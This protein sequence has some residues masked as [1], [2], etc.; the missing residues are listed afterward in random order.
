MEEYLESLELRLTVERLNRAN[1]SRAAQLLNKTNQMN[2]TTRRMTETQLEVHNSGDR[3][4]FVF[5]V[6]DRFGEYGVTGLAGLE[7]NGDCAIVAD[8]VVSCRVMGR[9]VENAM[10]HVL[11]EYACRRGA[12][13]IEATFLP[14]DRNMPLKAFFDRTFAKSAAQFDDR[15]RYTWNTVGLNLIPPHIRL[16]RG[17]VK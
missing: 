4:V 5:Q 13:R 15:T 16:E 9:G 10:L 17:L 14:T 12:D 11:T 7:M 3:V 6:A 8:F 2:L 1:L